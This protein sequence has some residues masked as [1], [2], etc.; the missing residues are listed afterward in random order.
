MISTH[1]FPRATLLLLPLL[2]AACGGEET[3]KPP[4]STTSGTTT[5][6]PTGGGG[7]GGTGG[8]GQG[9]TGGQ[10]LCG[11]GTIDPGEQC[12]G[13][14]LGTA[15]CQSEGFDGGTLACAA[16]C[17]LNVSNCTGAEIC[18][19][20]KDND[21]DGLTDCEERECAPACEDSCLAPIPLTDPADTPGLSAGHANQLTPSCAAESGAEVAYSITAATTGMLDAILIEDGSATFSL[22]VR[23][24][25]ASDASEL[26]CTTTYVAGQDSTLKLSVPVTEGQTLILVVDTE[27]ASS[28]GT[29]TLGAQTR[30]ILCG[31]GIQD[32][33]EACDDA[34]TDAGDGC[35]P[36][37]T[38]ESNEVEPNDA[39]GQAAP[40]AAPYFASISPEGDIDFV[41][42]DLP[43]PGGI[44][45]SVN[46]LGEMACSDGSMDS[47]LT[48]LDDQGKVLAANDDV[49][50]GSLCSLAAAP[51][52]AAGTYYAKIEASPM[53]PPDAATFPYEL[54][55]TPFACG[56]GVKDPGEECDDGNLMSG[57][58]CTPTCM[59]TVTETEPNDTIGQ[60][61]PYASP[62]VARI[63][64]DNDIDVISVAVPGPASK[65][66]AK[67]LSPD[68]G[69][70]Y[71]GADTYVE[72][73]KADGTVLV[74]NEDNGTYC[75]TATAENLAAGTYYIRV[76]ATPILDDALVYIFPY[77]LEVTVQ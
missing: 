54:T 42:I 23:T 34:N 17:T 5:T 66:T 8:G 20:G 55:V 6:D 51:G 71:P 59:F 60:S 65:L 47:Y 44:K 40:F 46:G 73:L 10:S 77:A 15:T 33:V 3:K 75:S 11:N 29:Y 27:G 57:D 76:Q 52:L 36:T 67:T 24:D 19:D 68:G 14:A 1:R 70:C 28:A 45:V 30:P 56:D 26:G 12:D 63:D 9:G 48:L 16:D 35:S 61:A 64:P 72:I 41:Q 2:V 13:D 18:G 58:A 22:S 37:C 38:L 69:F 62:W 25:C 49:V 7:Q 32:S 31:D 53:S 74:F 21:G 43:S 4:I 39:L 50:S